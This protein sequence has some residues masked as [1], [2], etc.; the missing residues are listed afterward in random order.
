M[1]DDMRQVV[2][3]IY[4]VL[5]DPPEISDEWCEELGTQIASMLKDRLQE[6]EEKYSLRLSSLGRGNRYLWYSVR[7]T[8]PKEELRPETRLKFLFGDVIELLYIALIE[9]AGHEVSHEQEEVEINGI[10][11]HIDC[12]VDGKLVDIKST[13]TFSFAK[14]DKETL[15]MP[16][17][18]PFGYYAQLSAYAFATGYEPAGWLVMDKQL[19]KLCFSPVHEEHLPDMEERVDKI[20]DVVAQPGEPAPCAYPVPDGK[21]GNQKLPTVCSY[22]PYKFHC[23]RDSNNGHGL[24]TF[25]YSSGPVF[26]THVAR[27]PKVPEITNQEN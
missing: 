27:L 20:K 24:R 6:R 22:C 1:H 5:L 17:K 13:S 10:K 16:D 14:F 2:E 25:L 7:D 21:S 18:D 9:L 11:G 19:G 26:L 12:L 4:K 3:D 23:W 15:H 8:I